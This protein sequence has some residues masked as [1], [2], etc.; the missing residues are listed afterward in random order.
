MTYRFLLIFIALFLEISSMFIRIPPNKR[1]CTAKNYS[2]GQSI[3]FNY[4]ILG[5]FNEKYE[6][7]I[8]RE[9]KEIIFKKDG[10]Q[11]GKY[12]GK[13][14]NK[15]NYYFCLLNSSPEEMR[16]NFN[17]EEKSTG[18]EQ[19]SVENINT[20]NYAV[21][22]L[23]RTLDKIDINIK[24]GAANRE[25]HAKIAHNIRRRITIFTFLKI[26]FLLVFSSFQIIMVSSVVQKVKVVKKIEMGKG[27]KGSSENKEFL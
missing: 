10:N 17:F 24:N 12:E 19:V 22:F 25:R 26:F 6:A 2:T 1:Q 18:N 21:S 13:I 14:N 5:Y 9:D 20:L 23:K 3:N 4:F 11:K 7:Y 8:Q 16:V 27:N 15:G